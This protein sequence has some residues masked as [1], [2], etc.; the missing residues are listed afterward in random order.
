M[1]IALGYDGP[2]D[3]GAVHDRFRGATV[4]GVD[5]TLGLALPFA[6]AFEGRLG[7]TYTRY[8]YTFHPTP[9]DAFVAGGALDEFFGITLGG[10]YVY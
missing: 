3:A 10:A 2:L 6:R 9:G 4:G 1:L 8:F 7:A 5:A